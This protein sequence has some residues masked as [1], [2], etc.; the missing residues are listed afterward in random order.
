METESS[1]N[2]ITAEGVG[3]G[4]PPLKTESITNRRRISILVMIGLEGY[5]HDAR[6]IQNG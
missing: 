1:R 2:K 6:R 4:R 3:I 5:L